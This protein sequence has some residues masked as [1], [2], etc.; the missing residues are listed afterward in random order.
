M[1]LW[2]VY[3]V[4]FVSLLTVSLLF[5]SL[6]WFEIECFYL[7]IWVICSVRL[8]LLFISVSFSVIIEVSRTCLYSYFL[9]YFYASILIKCWIR[10]DVKLY[11]KLCVLNLNLNCV[12][13]AKI[14]FGHE[15]IYF[16]RLSFLMY[17]LVFCL[18]LLDLSFC[19]CIFKFDFV[20]FCLIYV[21]YF[22]FRFCPLF[23]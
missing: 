14:C 4:R 18:I 15:V 5:V 23:K 16:C 1:L 6:R 7:L 12:K 17:W 2:C 22:V 9:F 13:C 3:I 20:I 21:L 8:L 19:I 11:F 10:Y